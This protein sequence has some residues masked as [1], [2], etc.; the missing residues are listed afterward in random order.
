MNYYEIVEITFVLNMHS[1]ARN[2]DN[3]KNKP[4]NKKRNQDMQ[5]CS[6]Y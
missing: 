4:K 6:F 2:K 1:I 3:V 5:S